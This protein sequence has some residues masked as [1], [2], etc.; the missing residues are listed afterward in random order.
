MK[1]YSLK[2]LSNKGLKKGVYNIENQSIGNNNKLTLYLIFKKDFSK[3]VIVKAYNRKGQ[4]IGRTKLMVDGKSGDAAYFD[5]MFD[6]RTDIGFRNK[7]T[8]E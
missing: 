7:I 6:K 5:F 4:E 1:F 2:K 3:E 8:I